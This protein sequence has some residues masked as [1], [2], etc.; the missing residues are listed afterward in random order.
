M[1]LQP[2]RQIGMATASYTNDNIG[3]MPFVPDG[4]LQ[5]TPSVND[6]GKRYNSMGS[7]MPLLDPYVGS[8]EVWV[9]V[10]T[11]VVT[12]DSWLM[13][14]SSPW[15]ENGVELPER[16]WSNYISD[17]LAELNPTKAR[18][19]RGRTPESCQ[20]SQHEHRLR[21]MADEPVLL[22]DPGGPASTSCGLSAT[23]SRRPTLVR[24]RR[25][26]QQ[27]YLD[28]RRLGPQGHQALIRPRAVIAEKNE[29]AQKKEKKPSFFAITAFHFFRQQPICFVSSFRPLSVGSSPS[30]C[31]T[32]DE[33]LCRSCGSATV[34]TGVFALGYVLRCSHIFR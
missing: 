9:S 6:S 27:L 1:P 10:P 30:A 28:F 15:R 32:I 17:K 3:R 33:E 4:D 23:A 20:A 24:P 7:F 22:S 18:Y 12:A 14:F 13:H 25:R 31:M 16:G 29:R 8:I 19:L 26:P 11:K 34:G 2:L 21:G 5:F